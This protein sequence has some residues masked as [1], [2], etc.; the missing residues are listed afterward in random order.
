MHKV[1]KKKNNMRRFQVNEVN[2]NESF[3]VFEIGK[4][5]H[6][7]IGNMHNIPRLVQKINHQLL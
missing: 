4:N 6:T 5:D 1:C 3:Q 7:V 2:F